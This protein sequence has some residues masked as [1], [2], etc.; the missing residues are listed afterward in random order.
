M[1]PRAELKVWLSGVLEGLDAPSHLLDRVMKRIDATY[2]AAPAPSVQYNA[3]PTAVQYRQPDP[4]P[5]A[6]TEAPTPTAPPDEVAQK[7]PP[8]RKGALAQAATRPETRKGDP[9]KAPY[10]P[11]DPEVLLME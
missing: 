7:F 1:D 4:R 2:G 5:H 11:E 6:P 9:L 10:K 3:D 8:R